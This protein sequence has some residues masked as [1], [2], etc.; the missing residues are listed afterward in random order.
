MKIKR[1]NIK[2]R[3]SKPRNLVDFRKIEYKTLYCKI[4]GKKVEMCAPTS[5]YV[6]CSMCVQKMLDPPR[7]FMQKK[8]TVAKPRGWKFMKIFV[9]SEQN[10]FYKGKEQPELKGTLDPTKII[11]KPKKKKLTLREKENFEIEKNH[12]FSEITSLKKQLLDNNLL[13][14]QKKK[15]EKEI[16]IKEKRIKKILKVKI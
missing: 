5:I 10:V 8:P 14:K 3:N 15:I 6:T 12:L 1:K 4:C 13:D 2:L 9:D 7:G 11:S 16:S